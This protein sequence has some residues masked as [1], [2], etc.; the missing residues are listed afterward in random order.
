ML[1]PKTYTTHDWCAL[2]LLA[3]KSDHSVSL[4]LI[5]S[6]V[7]PQY[8]ET[9]VIHQ[10]YSPM[11]FKIY[12]VS[13]IALYHLCTMFS[14]IQAYIVLRVRVLIEARQAIP[15]VP[16]TSSSSA[17]V[18]SITSMFEPLP[19]SVSITFHGTNVAANKLQVQYFERRY[20]HCRL[21]VLEQRYFDCY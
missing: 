5:D 19:T 17:S 13:L 8:R 14:C 9:H 4:R 16:L 12:K 7:N 18:V 6:S 3:I 11:F 15:S 20:C 21:V 2:L 1:S 10:Q